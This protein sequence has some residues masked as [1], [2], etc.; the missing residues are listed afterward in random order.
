[1]SYHPTSEQVSGMCAFLEAMSQRHRGGIFKGPR[2]ALSFHRGARASTVPDR[3]NPEQVDVVLALHR[4]RVPQ[5]G[6]VKQTGLSRTAV[7]AVCN[8]SGEPAAN[9]TRR[10]G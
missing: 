2:D 10:R 9:A 1:M 6:I 4:Q 7:R 5:E 3:I 8:N